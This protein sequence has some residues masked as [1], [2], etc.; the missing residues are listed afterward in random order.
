MSHRVE[1]Y[2]EQLDLHIPYPQAVYSLGKK[3]AE[4]QTD[5]GVNLKQGDENL[6]TEQRSIAMPHC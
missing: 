1:R 3:I 6:R 4:G 2:K 5:E